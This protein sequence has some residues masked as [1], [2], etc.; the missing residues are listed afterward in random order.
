MEDTS[1]DYVGF[2]ERDAVSV[3]KGQS[4]IYMLCA[5]P[6]GHRFPPHQRSGNLFANLLTPIYIGRTTD[7]HQRFLRHCRNPSPRVG[8][9]S[10]CFQKSLTFWFHRVSPE[11]LVYDEAVLIRCFAPPANERDEAIPASIG[12]PIPLALSRTEF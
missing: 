6:V 9:A 11:R 10:I 8:A 12:K 5:S 1:W 4:G 7:L 3:P 2:T